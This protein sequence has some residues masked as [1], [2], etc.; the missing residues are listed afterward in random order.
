MAFS[1]FAAACQGQL[2]RGH[3]HTLP[4]ARDLQVLRCLG[5]AHCRPRR[6]CPIG[7][8]RYHTA[9]SLEDV[10]R[11]GFLLCTSSDAQAPMLKSAAMLSLFLT[12]PAV[13]ASLLASHACAHL[14]S[15]WARQPCLPRRKAWHPKRHDLFCVA[16]SGR[17]NFG[18]VGGLRR[19]QRPAKAAEG[20]AE[21]R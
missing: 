16:T 11:S 21:G 13:T 2:G 14:A 20:H 3:L 15:R 10:L 17:G 4:S 19:D 7:S 9:E 8:H 18:V 5:G 1:A 12:P 6:R